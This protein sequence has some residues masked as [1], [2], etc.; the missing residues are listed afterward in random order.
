MKSRLVAAAVLT[1]ALTASGCAGTDP[2]AVNPSQREELVYRTGSNIP[3]RG[4]TPMTPEE[5]EKQAEEAR[6]T[7]QQMQTTGAGNP[8]T[9]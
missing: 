9:N 1:A 5:K 3:V 4:K 6:R 2:A 7:F 8:R